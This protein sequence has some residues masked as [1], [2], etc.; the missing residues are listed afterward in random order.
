MDRAL[1]STGK[2]ILRAPAPAAGPPAG[3]AAPSYASRPPAISDSVTQDLSNNIAASSYGAGEMARNAMDRSGV[4]RGKGQAYFGDIAQAQADVKAQ[5]GAAGAEMEAASANAKA[6]ADYDNTMRSEQ[7]SNAGLLEALRSSQA[8]ERLANRA[9][10][11]D[12]YEALARG[13]FGLDSMNLDTTSLLERLL[14]G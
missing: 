7:L 12:I 10:Q 2:P 8:S 4:S 6:R 1:P 3:A 13:R 14:R 5:A 9:G 11:Q